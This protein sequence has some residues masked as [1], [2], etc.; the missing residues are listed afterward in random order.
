MQ[1]K[2]K[3]KKW[4]KALVCV[5]SAITC[6]SAF[7]AV[8]AL[9]TKAENTS[10]APENTQTQ[11]AASPSSLWNQANGVTVSDNGDIPTW[12]KNGWRVHRADW[13]AVSEEYLTEEDLPESRKKGVKVVNLSDY[14]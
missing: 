4:R 3:N 11:T 8:S 2:N 10:K 5:L 7:A 6:F 12:A 13:I 1:I 9:S 14:I